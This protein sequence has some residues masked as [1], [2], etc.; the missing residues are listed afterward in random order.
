MTAEDMAMK[1]I[2]FINDEILR[3][4]K[5]MQQLNMKKMIMTTDQFNKEHGMIV[6]SVTTLHAI[7]QK[8][9]NMHIESDDT[10]FM[11]KGKTR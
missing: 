2:S 11:Y 4:E 3:Q 6:G 1:L 5:N 9:Q 7:A 8:V 10:K